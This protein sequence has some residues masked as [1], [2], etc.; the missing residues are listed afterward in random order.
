VFD[1][2]PLA[3]GGEVRQKHEFGVSGIHVFAALPRPCPA[4]KASRR[5]RWDQGLEENRRALSGA[6]F[7]PSWFVFLCL[8]SAVFPLRTLW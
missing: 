1:C 3:R 5:N 4:C 8:P 7:E 6:I 2:A